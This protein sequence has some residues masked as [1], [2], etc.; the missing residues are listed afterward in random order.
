MARFSG[1]LMLS[2]LNDFIT[3]SQECIKPVVIEKIPGPVGKIRIDD[4]GSYLQSTQDGT[5]VKLGKAKITLN[6]CLAC[7]GCITSAESVMIS[8]QSQEEL[9]QILEKNKEYRQ[10]D[11]KDAIKLVVVTIAPQVRVSLGVKYNLGE[12]ETAE[13]LTG[14]FKRL[15]V[16]F[17]FDSTFARNFSLI[18]S[19]K[20]FIRRFKANETEPDSLPMICSS[21]PGWVCY[22][23]KTHGKFIL[24]YMS[25]SKSPQQVMG[26]LVKDYLARNLNLTRD[27]I[28][29]VSIEPCFD[30]KLE[31]SRQDFYD[32]QFATRDV[33]CVIT[34]LEVDEMLDRESISL[35]DVESHELDSL[36][37]N[38]TDGQLV[39]IEGSA[40]GGYAQS[41][42]KYAA[43][44]LF[45]EKLEELQFK[46]QVNFQEA[47]FELDGRVVLRFA[48]VYGFRNIQNF[49]QRLKRRKNEYHYVEVMACPSGCLNG[50]AQIRPVDGETSKERTAKLERLYS[51]V[52]TKL[53]RDSPQVSRLW[54]EWLG[55]PDK[56]AR[57]LHTQF[58]AVEKNT[59]AL[60]IK[61]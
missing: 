16:D 47:T 19:Q 54:E 27:R 53:P 13:K 9:Y 40:S 11:C 48:L 21:C 35:L 45:G 15:G 39:G 44:E 20:E 43:H 10:I 1:P 23:E 60:N 14:F 52:P 32:T 17:V 50:G 59:I 4:D 51:T 58:R 7:S 26:S 36:F 37:S 5:E 18:C 46:P 12:Q 57:M 2:D 42:M 24:P 38:T 31:A 22:A 33:D 41:V 25:T 56:E 61:W 34:T 28:Y 8:Q 49:V 29:V 3:P 6:D 30:K 55:D